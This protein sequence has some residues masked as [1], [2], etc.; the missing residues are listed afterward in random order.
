MK[1]ELISIIVPVYNCEQYIKHCIKSILMQ[2]Y[3]KIEVL[4]INDGS[5][6][7]TESIIE[8]FNDDRIIYLKKQNTGVSDTRN[9]GIEAAKG[10]YILFVDS[11]DYLIENMVEKMY[12]AICNNDLDVV[13]ANYYIKKNNR[14]IDGVEYEFSNK[15][16]HKENIK[17]EIIPNILNHKIKGYVWLL[18]IKKE[19]INEVFSTSLNILEDMK[20]YIDLFFNIDKAMFL[21]EKLYIYNC[22]NGFSATKDHKYY[23]RNMKNMINATYEIMKTLKDYNFSDRNTIEIFCTKNINSIINYNYLLYKSDYNIEKIK[24]IWNNIIND[25]MYKDIVKYYNQSYS[26]FSEKII[27]RLLYK[28]YYMILKEIFRIRKFIAKNRRK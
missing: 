21:S 13:R 2:T 25:D 28:K 20:F 14:L 24:K 18:L 7:R 26:S 22:D 6:D 10:K 3:K 12:K 15:V 8:E 17:N 11:D 16:L 19:K 4:V 5:T 1:E 27:Y 9:L 23:E